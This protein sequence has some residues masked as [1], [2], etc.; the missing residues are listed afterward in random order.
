MPLYKVHFRLK[1]PVARRDYDDMVK[2][3]GTLTKNKGRDIMD[4]EAFNLRVTGYDEIEFHTNPL[5]LENATALKL[6]F[7]GIMIES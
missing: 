3:A 6:R 4:S 2:Y 1:T 5:T 7:N